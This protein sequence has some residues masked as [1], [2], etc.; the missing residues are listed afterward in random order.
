MPNTKKTDLLI[1]GTGPAGYTASIY[2]SRYKISHIIVGN[3]IG[4]QVSKA[5]V[6]ENYPGFVSIKG[7]ELAQKFKAHAEHFLKE[8]NSELIFNTVTSIKKHPQGF[9]TTL[10]D[11]ST[12]TSKALIFAIGVKKRKL[13]IPGEEKFRGRGVSECVTCDGFFYRNK[14]VGIVG[15]GD[16]A[17]TGALYLAELSPKVY[18]FVRR[19]K[20]RAEP[21]WQKQIQKRPN[22]EVLYNTEL[23]EIYGNQKVEGVVTKDGRRI[24][25]EGVFIEIGHYPDLSLLQDLNPETDEEGYIKVAT[26]QSTSV[27]G[28]YAAGDITTANNKFKQIVVAAAEGA[29]A[30]NSVFNYLQRGR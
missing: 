4:G 27:P 22:I 9:E 18:M 15:G 28:L 16:S 6:V 3:I 25:L 30:A 20:M 12:I 26:D 13:G 5:S 14:V 23:A 10:Q 17:A 2:A 7:F 24:K 29:V 21:H 1:V 8:S 19:D 11:G